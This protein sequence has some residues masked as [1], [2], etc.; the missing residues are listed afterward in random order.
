M[1]DRSGHV[2]ATVVFTD[3]VD[4]S[5]LARELGDARWRV[6]PHVITQSSA[7]PSSGTTATRSTTPATASSPLRRSGDA[8]RCACEI[9]DGVK[10]LG[11][12]V[13]AGA[14]WVRRR[15]WAE[16][17]RRNRPRRCSG[18]VEAQPGEV[19]V[20]GVMKDLVP[21]SGFTFEDRGVHTLKGIDG[22][23]RLFA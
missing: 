4:S 2:L 20:S 6:L 9:A 8:I 10:V 16:T 13:R 17:R 1:R 12:E 7:R 15:W 3:I 5:T 21:A 23:W 14:T 11:I 18:H 19:L 22:E